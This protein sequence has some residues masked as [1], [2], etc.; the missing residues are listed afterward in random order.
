VDYLRT[1]AGV[2]V[3]YLRLCFWPHPLCLD[4]HWPLARTARE[5]YLPGAAILT[6][7]LASFA[8]LWY[9]PRLGFVGLASSSSWHR[10]PA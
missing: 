1:Q 10:P 7:L 4:Y 8:A 5:I 3:H 9:R 6:L 2:L